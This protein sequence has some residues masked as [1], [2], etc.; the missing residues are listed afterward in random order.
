MFLLQMEG[1]RN[2]NPLG[3]GTA[4]PLKSSLSGS[5]I[6]AGGTITLML[7]IYSHLCHH[8]RYAV[9]FAKDVDKVRFHVSF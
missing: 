2:L 1:K 6:L 3:L 8:I 5:T 7:L 9:S 4:T